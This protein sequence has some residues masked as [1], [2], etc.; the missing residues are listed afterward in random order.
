MY[1]SVPTL[2]VR[3]TFGVLDDVVLLFFPAGFQIYI[4]SV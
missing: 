4:S 2:C 3:N 1:P